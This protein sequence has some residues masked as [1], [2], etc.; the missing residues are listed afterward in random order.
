METTP[1][2]IFHKTILH[3]PFTVTSSNDATDEISTGTR[4]R[5]IIRGK[6]LA[7]FTYIVLMGGSDDTDIK[8]EK[9]L[10]EYQDSCP[11]FRL[12]GQKRR[13]RRVD[14]HGME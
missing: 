9:A 6:S 2:F 11:P 5:S 12:K 1:T 3:D 7:S 10:L 13:V 4:S 8:D 14:V